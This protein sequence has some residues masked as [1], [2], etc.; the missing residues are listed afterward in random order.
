MADINDNYVFALGSFFCGLVILERGADNFIDSSVAIA[1]RSGVSP[2]LIGL[3]TCGAEWEELVVMLLALGQGHSPLALGNLVGSNIANI[4]GSFSLGL[5]FAKSDMMFDASSRI[6][7]AVC[8]GTTLA[9]LLMFYTIPATFR[10]LAG[11]ALM[12]AFAIYIASVT[13]LIYKGTLV[14]PENEPDSDTDSDS[15]SG[16]GSAPALEYAC[17]DELELRSRSDNDHT[18][19]ETAAEEISAA[20][21]MLAADNQP[22]TRRRLVT[23]LL[24]KRNKATKPLRKL[25]VE[26]LVGLTLILVSGYVIAASADVLG[27]RFGLSD[28]VTGA[29]IVSLA[30]TVPEKIVALK[31]GMREQPEILVANTAG[32][33][34]F[35]TLCGGAVVFIWGGGEVQGQIRPTEAL[36]MCASASVLLL[37]VLAGGKRWMG[38]VLMAAYLVFLVVEVVG[39]RQPGDV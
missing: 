21:R 2:T 30:T 19:D 8:L 32:S 36:T 29:T 16:S 3:L 31:S 37:I 33:N 23:G 25:A 7:T 24:R 15:G 9:F 14:A 27:Q 1:A 39:G 20:A 35:L 22:T 4:L 5:L 13:W 11:V 12:V 26:L 10:W 28:S 34:I 6:Y 18:D 17:Q 38:G